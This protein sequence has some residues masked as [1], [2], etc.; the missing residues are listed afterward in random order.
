MILTDEVH[1]SQGTATLEVNRQGQEQPVF[2]NFNNLNVTTE[3]AWTANTTQ[4]SKLSATGKKIGPATL[5]EVMAGD[6]ISAKTD[7]FYLAN[8]NSPGGESNL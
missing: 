6:E 3:P 7:Y 2:G 4:V 1:S 8:P 5:L